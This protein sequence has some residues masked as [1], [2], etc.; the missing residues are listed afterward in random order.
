MNTATAQL[1][2]LLNELHSALDKAWVFIDDTEADVPHDKDLL[3]GEIATA[4]VRV[5]KEL[6]R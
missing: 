6:G 2:K 5:R 4:L 1:T 3:M